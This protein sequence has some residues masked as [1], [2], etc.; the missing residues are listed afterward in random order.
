MHFR[1]N[2]IFILGFMGIKPPRK[3]RSICRSIPGCP[4]GFIPLVCCGVTGKM[5]QIC[6]GILALMLNGGSG[7]GQWPPPPGRCCGK[8]LERP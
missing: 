8:Y 3:L 6:Q 7:R 1:L 4:V 2:D 5:C